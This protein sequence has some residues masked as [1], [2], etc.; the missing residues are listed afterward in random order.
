MA[1]EVF[2]INSTLVSLNEGVNKDESTTVI[3][4]SVVNSFGEKYPSIAI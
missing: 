1:V 2:L 4:I 3:G